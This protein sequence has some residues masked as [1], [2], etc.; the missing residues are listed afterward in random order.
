MGPMAA[1]PHTSKTH[2]TRE[3]S[4][5]QLFFL[6]RAGRGEGCALGSPRPV[7]RRQASLALRLKRNSCPATSQVA[8]AAGRPI[9]TCMTAKRTPLKRSRKRKRKPRRG[10]S[11]IPRRTFLQLTAAAAGGGGPGPDGL[12]GQD[13]DPGPRRRRPGRRGYPAGRRRRGGGR[14]ADLPGD[15]DADA[16]AA[17]GRAGRDGRGFPLRRR[18]RPGGAPRTSRSTFSSPATG[19]PSRTSRRH[20]PGRRHRAV[21]RPH[22]RGRA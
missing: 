8:F 21:R 9:I 3:V 18:R 11:A 2:C 12:H 4:H 10:G 17:S 16:D 14:A 7:P 15:R 13:G 20:P 19:R 22:R 6:V 1:P 5:L